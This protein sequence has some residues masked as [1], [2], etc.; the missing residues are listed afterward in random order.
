MS[1]KTDWEKRSQKYGGAL[2]GVLPK[3][4]PKPANEYLNKWMYEQIKP[5]L[6]NEKP[7]VLLDLGCGY[8]RL[9]EK[10]L[11][12][13]PK[14]K[15]NGIDLSSNYVSIFNK[16][17][18]PRGVAK[19]GSITKLPYASLSI[20]VVYMVTTFMYLTNE[21]DR[22]KAIREIFRVLRPGGRFVFIERNKIGYFLITL[23]GLI[24][25]IRGK[26]NKEIE[27]VSFSRKE[28][29]DL[30]DESGGVVEQLAG[31]P[32]WTLSLPKL[33]LLAKVNNSLV[34][35][36]MRVIAPID[37]LFSWFL[38]PSMYISYIGIKKHEKD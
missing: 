17:L 12:D 8:G 10:V 5:Q 29:T 37:K 16:K 9:A 38:T 30:I 4:F 6:T 31:I 23:G 22:K 24:E 18:N 26:K 15:V 35:L 1:I 7:Q 34:K 11:K 21:D 32:F 3:S 25:K 20:D 14:A 33:F 27:S 28:I 19:S 2:E 13:F 36:F